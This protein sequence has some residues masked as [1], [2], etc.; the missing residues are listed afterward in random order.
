MAPSVGSAL[1]PHRAEERHAAG[2][3]RKAAV[4]TMVVCAV[5][6]VLTLLVTSQVG[7]WNALYFAYRSSL[8]ACVMLV[9]RPRVDCCGGDLP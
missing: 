8:L 9:Q 6:T 5:A 1:L 4:S 3:A 7:C 2:T